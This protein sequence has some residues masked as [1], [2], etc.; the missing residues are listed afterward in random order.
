MGR[1]TGCS[2]LAGWCVAQDGTILQD[3]AISRNGAIAQEGTLH[4]MRRF[5]RLGRL[6]RIGPC[7]GC[8]DCTGWNV[9]ED[10]AIHRMDDFLH[11]AISRE[12]RQIT[13]WG[14]FHSSFALCTLAHSEHNLHCFHFSSFGFQFF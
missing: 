4:R 14:H 5:Y 10:G 7:A 2:D 1:W 9:A 11:R 3:V 12:D 6:H 8:G 13:A